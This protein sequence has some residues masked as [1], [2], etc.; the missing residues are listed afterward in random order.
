MSSSAIRP[1]Q[2][3]SGNSAIG[4]TCW[5]PALGITASSRPKLLERRVDGAAVAL[6]RGQV[7]GVGHAGAVVGGL[8]VDGEDAVSVGDEAFGDGAADPSGRSGDDRGA[9][10]HGRRV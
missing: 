1:S 9:L 5:K 8:E 7:G 6:A 2:R 4:A 10:R 3:S